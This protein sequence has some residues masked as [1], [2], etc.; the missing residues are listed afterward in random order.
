MTYAGAEF[1]SDDWQVSTRNVGGVLRAVARRLWPTNTA[2]QAANAWGLELTTAVNLTK[3]H[4]SE[5][6]ITKALLAGDWPLLMQLGEALYGDTYAEH[7]LTVAQEAEHARAQAAERAAYVARLER[8]AAGVE[9]VDHLSSDVP[10]R[11]RHGGAGVRGDDVGAAKGGARQ[12]T[13]R[14]RS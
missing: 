14:G 7:L 9:R 6:T 8:I 3:G 11:Q 10:H 1:L 4:A 12:V 2:K 5:R 13:G